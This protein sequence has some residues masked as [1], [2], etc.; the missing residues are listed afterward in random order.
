MEAE[1]RL[2]ADRFNSTTF[3]ITLLLEVQR[4]QQNSKRSKKERKRKRLKELVV[5]DGAKRGPKP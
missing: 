1:R 3:S 2:L 4:L 5:K